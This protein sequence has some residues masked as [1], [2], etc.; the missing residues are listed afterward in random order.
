MLPFEGS[1]CG[2]GDDAGTPILGTADL[3]CLGLGRYRWLVGWPQ[4][5][6]ADV[7]RRLGD[8]EED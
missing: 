5:R 6:Q 4:G 7:L 1:L 3:P 8:G 2:M